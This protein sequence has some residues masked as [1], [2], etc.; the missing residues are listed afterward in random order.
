[1]KIIRAAGEKRRV[2][3]SSSWRKPR[4]SGNTQKLE[5]IISVYL[6]E[7]F[8]FDDKTEVVDE[9]GGHDRLRL[10]GDYIKTHGSKEGAPERLHVLVLDDFFY[11]PIRGFHVG[12]T[13]VNSL[14]SAESY[15]E[16]CSP[17]TVLTK[18]K[19]VHTYISSTLQSGLEVQVGTGL[20]MQHLGDAL[21]FL[22]AMRRQISKPAEMPNVPDVPLKSVPGDQKA[23]WCCNVM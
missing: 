9:E 2:I 6:G 12:T 16:S 8:K 19:I 15:L 11:L 3:I 13:T 17:S 4:Y 14:E 21:T 5:T 23:K 1:V 7:S 10:I 20:S 22:G 18:A